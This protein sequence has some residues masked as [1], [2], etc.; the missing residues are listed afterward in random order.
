MNYYTLTHKM[1][2]S[3]IHIKT[4]IFIQNKK[5]RIYIMNV[6]F[7]IEGLNTLFKSFHN[8]SGVKIGVYLPDGTPLA[9]HGG[10][11]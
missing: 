2:N 11:D 3:K 5:E 10:N 6:R 7:D 9:A 8:I 1:N 4:S